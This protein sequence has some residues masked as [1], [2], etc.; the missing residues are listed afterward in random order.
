MHKA[1]Y[2]LA[3]N[4]NLAHYRRLVPATEVFGNLLMIG[5]R[6]SCTGDMQKHVNTQQP[7]LSACCTKRGSCHTAVQNVYLQVQITLNWPSRGHGGQLQGP[8]LGHSDRVWSDPA[9]CQAKRGHPTLPLLPTP[10][11][12]HCLYKVMRTF[13]SNTCLCV[14]PLPEK[15]DLWQDHLL[16]QPFDD[17]YSGKHCSPLYGLKDIPNKPSMLVTRAQNQCNHE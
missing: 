14:C 3:V 16:R 13:I 2:T 11:L 17:A 9:L 12:L 8:S 5:R 10:S 1:V 15:Q 6:C 4:P 7:F